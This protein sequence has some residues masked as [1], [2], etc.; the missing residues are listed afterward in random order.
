MQ[1]TENQTRKALILKGLTVQWVIKVNS[2]EEHKIG[3]DMAGSIK[4]TG[5]G[6]QCTLN[7]EL[8]KVAEDGV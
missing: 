6:I 4:A 7:K 2:S 3:V 8:S 5:K 1:G